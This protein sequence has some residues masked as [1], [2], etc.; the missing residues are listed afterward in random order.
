MK[1][2][3]KQRQTGSQQKTSLNL[4]GMISIFT[5]LIFFFISSALLFPVPQSSSASAATEKTGGTDGKSVGKSIKYYRVDKVMTVSGDI[6]EIKSE[7]SYNRSNFIVVYLKDI[8]TKQ[9]Y[10]V[11]ISPDWYF[12]LDLMKGNRIEVTGALN[13]IE[14]QN[15]VMTRTLVFQGKEYHFR[16]KNGFPLWRGEGR[17]YKGKG[18]GRG[19]GQGRGR[20]SSRQNRN[21]G[22]HRR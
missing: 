6:S 14:K 7:K 4:P 8:K 22:G 20:G 17:S 1:Q 13:R 3:S 10:K 16:D 15:L 2:I 9:P 18:Y 5:Y 19:R 11:E 12:Q 21:R